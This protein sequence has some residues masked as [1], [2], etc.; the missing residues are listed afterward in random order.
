MN[1]K[2]KKILSFLSLATLFILPLSVGAQF[3][4][5]SGFNPD[6]VDTGQG[7][8]TMTPK[9][10]FNTVIGWLL[11]ILGFLTV[12]GIIISGIMYVVGGGSTKESAKGWL[13]Y[14]IIGLVV[15]LLGYVI[16][17]IVQSLLGV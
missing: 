11:F 13:M 14:S 4:A 12:L 9:E 7:L 5:G 17:K 15:A 10:I 1:I 8:S 2:L 3:D 16:V 6:N